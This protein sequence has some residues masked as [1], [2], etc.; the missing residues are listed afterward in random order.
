M[1]AIAERIINMPVSGLFVKEVLLTL[2]NRHLLFLLIFPPIVQLIILGYSLDP[3]LHNLRLGIVDLANTPESRMLISTLTHDREIFLPNFL[4]PN[5]EL[6]VDDLLTDR[7]SAGMIIPADFSRQLLRTHKSEFQV[8]LNGVDAFSAKMARGYFQLLAAHAIPGQD[9][10]GVVRTDV[11]VAFNSG[12]TSAWY[13][14]PGVLG[15]L[16]TLSGTL[17]SSAAMLRE[18]ESGTL[19]QLLMLPVTSADIV[20]AKAVPIFAL[21]FLDLCVAIGLTTW[22][23]ALPFRGS[24]LLFLFCSALYILI[25]IGMGTLMATFCSSQRQAQL[26]SFFINIPII[27]LSGSVVPLETMPPVLKAISLLDPLRY[28]QT[29]SRGII[30]KGL[31]VSELFVEILCLIAFCLVLLCLN[32]LRFRRQLS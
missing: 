13:F 10:S 8:L 25:S 18:R 17:V 30:L 29:L 23:F 5:P 2:R 31:G 22:L 27:L 32:L 12:L 28:F 4:P 21:L 16:I 7:I 24:I 20:V 15:A 11:S 1:K 26:L 19:E 6:L 9:I 14:V 3:R